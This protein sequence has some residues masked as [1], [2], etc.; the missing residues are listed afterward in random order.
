MI[1][2]E[3][4]DK[5]DTEFTRTA[6]DTFRDFGFHMILATPLKLLQTLEEYVGGVGLAT[7]PDGR[8]SRID[9]VALDP[10]PVVERTSAA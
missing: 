4:F 5:A 9:V 2:D 3:A 10:T 8:E 7:C 6:M 1:L